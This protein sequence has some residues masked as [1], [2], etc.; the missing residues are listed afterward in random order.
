MHTET[1]PAATQPD[2][3]PN[4]A[5]CHTGAAARVCAFDVALLED[6]GRCIS[7]GVGLGEE[8]YSWCPQRFHGGA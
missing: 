2:E 7:C 6:F 1:L 8:H 3:P 4:V 5:P